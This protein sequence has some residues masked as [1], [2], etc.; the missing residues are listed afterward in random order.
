MTIIQIITIFS[1]LIYLSAVLRFDLQ[2]M[3]QNSYRNKRYFRWLLNNCINFH[4][5]SDLLVG[6]LPLFLCNTFILI[7]VSVFFV[8]KAIFLFRKKYKKPLVFTSRARRLYFSAFTLNLIAG[9]LCFPHYEIMCIFPFLSFFSI[10]FS[11]VL[12]T[13]VDKLINNWYYRDA[14]KILKQM[15]ELVI[16]GITGSYGKTSTKHYLHRILSEKYNVLITPGSFNTTLGVIRTIRES[17]KPYHNVFIVEMGAKQIG[18]IREI[19]DLVK[20]SIGIITAV[21]EQH[22]ESFKSI[23]NVQRTKFELIDSLPSEGLAVLNNDFEYIA[24]REVC[25]VK[26]VIRYAI[27]KRNVDL[28][29]SNIQYQSLETYFTVVDKGVE[30]NLETKLLGNANLSNLLACYAVAKYLGINNQELKIGV[31][32]IHQV[33]HR[34]SLKRTPGGVTII[35]DAFNSNPHGAKMALD[36][37]KSFEGNKKIIITPGLIELGEKQSMYNTEFGKKMAKTCDYAIVVGNYN[38]HSIVRG[39]EEEGFSQKN[40]YLADSFSEASK[41]LNSIVHSGDVVLYENDL[42]DTFK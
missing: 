5:I 35:D 40:I 11:I 12:N 21:G 22:L 8:L 32:R 4:R 39:L 38:R 10:M 19:C 41:H 1:I 20:P 24:N 36:V 3:Q 27:E 15:P 25:N 7:G 16:V 33:E 28:S 6:I 37:L 29:I 31:G 30:L 26:K 17:L 2:M 14:Q 9:V 13:P 34:L 23:E 42:P 18:D